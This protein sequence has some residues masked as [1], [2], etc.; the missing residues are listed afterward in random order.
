MRTLVLLWMTN[1]DS[2]QEYLAYM[3]GLVTH[4]LASKHP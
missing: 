1:G 3:A 2:Y 4:A